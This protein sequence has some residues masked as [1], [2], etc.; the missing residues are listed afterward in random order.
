MDLL[1]EVPTID[2]RTKIPDRVI[3]ELT[4]RIAE[5]FHPEK[6]ILFGSYA[7]GEPKPESDVDI[8]VIMNTQRREIQQALDIRQA[9][10]PLF[11]L[12]IIVYTP[13]KLKQR[14]SWG[15]SFL[16]EIVER[17]IVLYESP[18]A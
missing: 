2:Q 17:G 8:L 6:I 12:D 10:N 5:Q 16:K 15:D 13:E 4:R 9:L 18:G 14:I 1:L 3:Q 7:Y 11:G